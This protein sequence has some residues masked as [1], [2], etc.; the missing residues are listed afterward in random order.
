MHTKFHDRRSNSIVI[1]VTSDPKHYINNPLFTDSPPPVSTLYP[2]CLH[3]TLAAP[4]S[5]PFSSHTVPHTPLMQTSTLPA[6]S[7]DPLTKRTV[8]LVQ[9]WTAVERKHFLCIWLLSG[10]LTKSYICFIVATFVIRIL[11]MCHS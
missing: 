2:S 1:Q 5:Q 9:L 4:I 7:R 10:A 11:H 3:T 6:L 8:P